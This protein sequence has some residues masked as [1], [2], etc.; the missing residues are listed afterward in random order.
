MADS[1]KTRPDAEQD[2]VLEF[3]DRGDGVRVFVLNRPQAYNSL[4]RALIDAIQSA[5]EEARHD[6][7]VRVVV[8]RGAGRGFCAGHDL[9][10]L[11]TMQSEA[12]H[13]ALL[14]ACAGMMQT[15][16][17]YPKP[18]I[19][20]IHGTASA[21]GCQLVATADL[22]FAAEDARFGTPGV[23]IG[24]FCST[25]MVA[26]SRAVA[27]K[28]AMKMLLTGTPITAQEAVSIGL[29]NETYPA[30]ELDAQVEAVARQIASKSAYV[31]GLG[32]QAFRQ[33][34]EMS[35]AAA[36]TH[37][38][39]VVVKNLQAADAREGVAAFLDKRSPRWS[40]S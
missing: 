20:Q 40:D 34:A 25:P 18:I 28:H 39:D 26:L 5:L 6:R 7:A 27:V 16:H 11:R 30:E 10:E 35:L 12:E 4:S 37:C 36:Y 13:Y 15:L 19:A 22:A 23:N 8:V 38:N 2:A 3:E 33:Q 24:L 17:H 32:K 9:D 21:A 14:E 1:P 29:V 31:I